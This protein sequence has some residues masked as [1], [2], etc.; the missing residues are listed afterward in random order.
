LPI[1]KSAYKELRKAKLRHFKN[2][3]TMSELR[4]A[5]KKF[6][7]LVTEK[8]IKEAKEF[9]SSL[10]SKLDKA[11][12]KGIIHKNSASR[13]ASRLSKKLSSLAKA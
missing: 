8:K 2:I 12:V 4:T 3:S 11:A 9:L 5:V 1:K 13:K 6:E 10:T 7:K